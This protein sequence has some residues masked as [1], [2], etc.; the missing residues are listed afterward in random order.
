[1][2]VSVVFRRVARIEFDEATEWYERQQA[3]LGPRFVE[4]VQRLLDRIAE[5]PDSFP[6]VHSTVREALVQRFPYC[7]YYGEK[8]DQILVLAVFHTARDPAIWQR[9]T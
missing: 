2:S 5:Q 3:G 4:S 1:M 9:R 6:V 7:I 8:S